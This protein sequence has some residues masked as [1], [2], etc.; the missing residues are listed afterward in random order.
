VLER[1]PGAQVGGEGEGAN[2]LGGAD[3]PLRF[4][5]PDRHRA[6]LTAAYLMNKIS[7]YFGSGQR[8]SATIFSS[9]SP[10]SRTLASAASWWSRA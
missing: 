10:T 4:G 6:T 9:W 7:E 8:S 3:G 5:I 1:L 2:H